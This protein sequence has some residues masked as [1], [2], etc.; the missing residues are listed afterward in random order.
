MREPGVLFG[1]ALV[2]LGK[3]FRSLPTRADFKALVTDFK[4]ELRRETQQIRGEMSILHTA[5]KVQEVAAS[6]VET[7]VVNIE[8]QRFEAGAQLL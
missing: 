4:E 5:I 3:L 2:N 7:R 1:G 8:Q 6:A